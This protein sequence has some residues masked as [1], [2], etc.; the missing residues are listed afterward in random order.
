MENFR[1]T[2]SR[3]VKAAFRW[4]EDVVVR[5]A[6][7][8]IAICPSLVETVRQ[9]DPGANVELIENTAE[10]HDVEGIEPSEVNEL[11]GRLGLEGK[12]VVLYIGTFESYQGLDLL[13]GAMAALAAGKDDAALVLVGGKPEQVEEQQRGAER[14]GIKSACRFTGQVP[15]GQVAAYL[16]LAD[17]LVS[18]RTAGTNT[19]LKIF[20]YLR[21]GIP[22]VAT[23]LYTHTQVLNPEVS[24]LVPPEP[25]PLAAAIT[26]LLDDPELRASLAAAALRLSEEKYSYSLYV[27]KTR[28]VF[29][30]LRKKTVG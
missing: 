13:L 1:F 26:R 9:I 18:P 15:H 24:M 20:S 16:K 28:R 8:V 27:E 2:R 10:S 12:R 3:M 17:V 23:D 7:A 5:S 6:D 4:M 22:I 19:P 21:S 14:L 11:K 30:R 29:D 25:E